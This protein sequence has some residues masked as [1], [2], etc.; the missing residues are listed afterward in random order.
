M[1]SHPFLSSPFVIFIWRRKSKPVVRSAS[2]GRRR[3]THQLRNSDPIF[4]V[5]RR[6]SG[7]GPLLRWRSG[8][9]GRQVGVKRSSVTFYGC[10]YSALM[11]GSVRWTGKYGM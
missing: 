11:S 6:S 7:D 10:G 2:H 4:I 8:A 3:Y 9:R 1:S 5:G